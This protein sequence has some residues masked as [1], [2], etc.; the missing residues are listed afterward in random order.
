MR[1]IIV[2]F[3]PESGPGQLLNLEAGTI[4]GAEADRG[5]GELVPKPPA[6]PTNHTSPEQEPW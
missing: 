2:E 4:T 1:A 6:M 3:A 5:G